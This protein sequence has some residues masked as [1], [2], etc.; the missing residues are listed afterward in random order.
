VN[1]H[2]GRV[3]YHPADGLDDGPG[4]GPP[5]RVHVI[6][7]WTEPARQPAQWPRRLIAAA[8]WVGRF[9][10]VAAVLLVASLRLATAVAVAVAGLSQEVIVL[11]VHRGLQVLG[12][13]LVVWV[14]VTLLATWL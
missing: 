5:I 1:V 11:A 7:E 13:L 12:T 4:T 9:A 6:P 8:K 14:G 2:E 3:T 10:E